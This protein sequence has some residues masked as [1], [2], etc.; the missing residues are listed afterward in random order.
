MDNRRTFITLAV[1]SSEAHTVERIAVS[2]ILS[3]NGIKFIRYTAKITPGDFLVYRNKNLR[4][5]IV[6][7]TNVNQD[8]VDHKQQTTAVKRPLTPHH[9][10]TPGKKAKYSNSAE[11]LSVD[12]YNVFCRK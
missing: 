7:S 1:L 4:R 8:V 9:H 5:G 10:G 2:R 12:S 11:G 3:V 6:M